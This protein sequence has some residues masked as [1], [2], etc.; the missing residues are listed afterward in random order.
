MISGG[1]PA[2]DAAI[3]RY[4]LRRFLS[5]LPLGLI[6]LTAGGF[7]VM[8]VVSGLRRDGILGTGWVGVLLMLVAVAF[9]VPVVSSWRTRRW[10]MAFDATGFWWIRGKEIALIPW[11]S[12]AG[13]GI[14][15]ARHSTIELCPRDEID[16]DDP[17]L[18]GFVRDTE[19]LR[20][21]LP[22]LR[23]RIGIPHS[24]NPYEKALRQWAPELWFGLV[25]QPLSYAGQPDREGH[26]ERMARRGAG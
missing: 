18:W 11:D 22:R 4:G 2:A 26:R 23:Y 15:Y 13:V 21:G 10:V 24:P 8:G 16:R 7:G 9:A 6:T 14:Y 20:P 5:L 1:A 12:L 25:A 19:P 3:L 17:L